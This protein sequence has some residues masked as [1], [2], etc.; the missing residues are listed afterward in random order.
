MRFTNWRL[1]SRA[2]RSKGFPA[3]GLSRFAGALIGFSFLTASIAAQPRLERIS[4]LSPPYEA[5]APSEPVALCASPDGN[6]YLLDAQLA[7]VV[8]LSS[9]GQLLNEVGGPGSGLLQFNQPSDLSINSGLDLFVA[10]RGNDRILRL[11]RRLYYL[12]EFRSLENTPPELVFEKPRSVVQGPRGDLFLADEGNDRI[13]K[14]AP[15]G[16]VLFSFGTFGLERGSL[17][18]PFRIELD[19][20]NGIWVLDAL[21]HVVH[22][23]EYGGYVEDIPALLAGDPTG[24]AASAKIIW[25]GSD[26][27]L[28]AWDPGNRLIFNFNPAEIGIFDPAP[29]VDIFGR[30]DLLW[31]LDARGRIYRY[32]IVLPR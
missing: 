29:W 25:V 10:D 13:L 21:G 7:A 16:E 15:G 17:S 3:A 5:F 23:D 19:E 30:G 12:W 22:F 14:I 24:L 4:Q 18:R 6:L 31:I 1:K 20:V 32:R 27:C 8:M 11:N 2:C 26:S 9:E 28:W